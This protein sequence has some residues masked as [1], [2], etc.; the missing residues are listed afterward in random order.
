VSRFSRKRW[1]RF[2]WWPVIGR[3]LT[4]PIPPV[5]PR[6][7]TASTPYIDTPV[8]DPASPLLPWTI[9]EPRIVGHLAEEGGDLTAHRT[10]HLGER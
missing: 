6:H 4:G 9:A 5:P 3:V 8:R 2:T 7:V 10:V 1:A